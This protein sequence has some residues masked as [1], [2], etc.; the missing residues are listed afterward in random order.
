M[1][2]AARRDLNNGFGNTLSRS[3]EFAVTP[4]LFGAA[5]YY[6]DSRVGTTLVFTILL[7]VL[8][9]VGTIARWYYDYESRMSTLD[10]QHATR[11]DA[12]PLR[13]GEQ[14]AAR[15]TIDRSSPK[16]PTGV[17][18]DDSASAVK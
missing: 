13:S 11:R 6:L 18:L 9:L 14:V 8:A 2:V 17:R 16:L 4:T 10:E 3:F 12:S 7:L 1:D 5:G 15:V